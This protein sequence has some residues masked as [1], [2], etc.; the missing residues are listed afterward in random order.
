MKRTI[1]PVLMIGLLA[2]AGAWGCNDDDSDEAADRARL[3]EMETAIETFIGEPTC[4]GPGDCRTVALGV[5]PCGGPWS[6]LAFN[7]A[8]IDTTALMQMVAEYNRFNAVL[9]E[10][11]GWVSDCMLVEPPALDCLDGHCTPVTF[12]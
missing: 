10:R 2:L 9:N 1:A 8:K 5:K 6:Y 3:Q 12:P 7:A 11:Y 4:G